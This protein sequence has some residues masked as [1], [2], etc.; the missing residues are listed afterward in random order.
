M[1]AA[2]LINKELPTLSL[3]DTVSKAM[4]LMDEFKVRHLPV[5]EG[6]VY[7]GLVSEKFLFELD[8]NDLLKGHANALVRP[9]MFEDQ[10]LFDALKLI[11]TFRI[12][13]VPVLAKDE[14][15]IG[16]FTEFSLARS[17]TGLTAVQQPGGIIVLE[18]PPSDYTLT[19]IA[20]I[21]ESNDGR[22]LACYL[23]P[24]KDS[25]KI[26]VTLKINREDLSAI[27]SAFTRYNYKV[28]AAFHQSENDE[29]M[30]K[31][32]ELFMNY[33]NM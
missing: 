24:Q 14:K 15:Y 3:K 8:E 32:F 19:Q 31:R 26:E 6:D 33:M 9:F 1:I 7:L 25:T 28:K 21:V 16:S 11:D 10:H 22:I 29:D 17:I 27:L 30:R 12:S 18:M 13:L 23:A 20:Q 5:V 4:E 2:E